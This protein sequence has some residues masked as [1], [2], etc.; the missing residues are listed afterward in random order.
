MLFVTTEFENEIPELTVLA[1]SKHILI[2]TP[3]PTNDSKGA[4]IN[5]VK[6]DGKQKFELSE[7][8]LKTQASRFPINCYR[9]QYLLNS[10]ENEQSYSRS[11]T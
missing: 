9:L 7:T 10:K 3:G 6:I 8:I 4:G 11:I 5:L 2:V 1:N